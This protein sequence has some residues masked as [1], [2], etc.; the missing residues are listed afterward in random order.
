MLSK[1]SLNTA[2]PTARNVAAR[3]ASSTFNQIRGNTG[4]SPGRAASA[5]GLTLPDPTEP[6]PYDKVITAEAKTQDGLLRVHNLKNKLYFE[7]PKAVLEQ[8]L[9]MGA[10]ATAVPAGQEHV[11]RTLNQDVLRFVLHG[12]FRRHQVS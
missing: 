10:N 8:P 9:L 1:T 3:N 11:G 5:A 6:K 4:F 2:A 7:I 12:Q